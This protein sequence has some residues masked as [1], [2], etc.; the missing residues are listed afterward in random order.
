MNKQKQEP[1]EL[2]RKEYEQTRKAFALFV[3]K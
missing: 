1:K 3:G 2:V